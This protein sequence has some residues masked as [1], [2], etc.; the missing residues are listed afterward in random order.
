VTLQI[1]CF[2]NDT[3]WFHDDKEDNIDDASGREPF[4][5]LTM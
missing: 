1:K 5:L 4:D 3:E 2:A